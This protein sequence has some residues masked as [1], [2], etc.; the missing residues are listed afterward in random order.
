VIDANVM[1]KYTKMYEGL[2]VAMSQVGLG[3]LKMTHVQLRYHCSA[4]SDTHLGDFYY[5]H[6]KGLILK[7]KFFYG[8]DAP[9]FLT[10]II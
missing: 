2:T 6:P 5:C 8:L 7:Q 1:K 3:Q 4:G 9:S 10:A